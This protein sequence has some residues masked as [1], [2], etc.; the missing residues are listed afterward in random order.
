MHGHL[1]SRSVE[2]IQ[3]FRAKVRRAGR[4]V[5][6]S[7]GE[8]VF[9]GLGLEDLDEPRAGLGGHGHEVV[10]ALAEAPIVDGTAGEA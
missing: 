9:G 8:R 1:A 5:K 10:G 3:A 7:F 4:L 2:R 6:A